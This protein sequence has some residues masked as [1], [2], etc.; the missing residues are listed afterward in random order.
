[1]KVRLAA[2]SIA[3]ALVAGCA[4]QPKPLQGAFD[5]LSPHDA[6]V[7]D[8]TGRIK[9]WVD[10]KPVGAALLR[11]DR[12]VAGASLAQQAPEMVESVLASLSFTGVHADADVAGV[13]TA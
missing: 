12:F 5:A 1:M 11:P 8:H 10:D 2:A 3:I 7:G 9:R 4:T 13:R 6:V